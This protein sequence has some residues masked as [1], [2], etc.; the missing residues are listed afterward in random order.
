MSYPIRV[1]PDAVLCVLQYLRSKTVVTSL[2]SADK[3][4]TTI[5]AS[6]TS[7]PYVLVQLMSS[8]GMW[9]AM[10]R[11]SFQVDV[12]GGTKADNYTLARSIRAA[13]WAI[14][15]DTVSAGVLVSASEEVGPQ[16]MPDM[17]PTPPLSRYTARYSV[18]VHP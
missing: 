3:I 16:W 2:I 6:G 7:Y 11:A 15:N 1:L 4:V 17:I 12:V 10:D 13:I 9:P 18:I 5:P 14:A 8:D